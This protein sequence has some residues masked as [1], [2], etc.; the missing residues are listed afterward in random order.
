MVGIANQKQ[1]MYNEGVQ[2]IQDSIDKVAGLPVVRE[3]DK[4]YLQSKLN[5]LGTKLKTFVGADYSNFQLTNNVMGMTKQIAEDP[6]VINAVSNTMKYKEQVKNMQADISNGKSNPAN[7]FRFNKRASQWL[8]STNLNDSFNAYYQSP[9]D[10]W[11]KIKDIA[12]EVGVDEQDV[13]QMYQTDERG[14]V[15]RDKKNRRTCLE[16][17]NG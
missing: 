17:Y 6:N 2:K 15:I 11:A 14:E 5:S 3:V 7:N 9:I 8:N 4:Q 10:V 12:K 13:Q 16:S 1:Q